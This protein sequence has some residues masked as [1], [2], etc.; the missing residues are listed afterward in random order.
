[1]QPETL[2]KPSNLKPSP[3][4]YSKTIRWLNP[5]SA[6]AKVIGADI[7]K[8]RTAAA[9]ETKPGEKGSMDWVV[10]VKTKDSKLRTEGLRPMNG[11]RSW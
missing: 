1:M 10:K 8:G 7:M 11:N 4:P 5:V 9:K 6:A 3:K 2:I